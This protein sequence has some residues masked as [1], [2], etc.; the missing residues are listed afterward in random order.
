MG[1]E[2]IGHNSDKLALKCSGYD[3]VLHGQYEQALAPLERALEL[4]RAELRVEQ[5]NPREVDLHDEARILAH[6]LECY[7]K[8]ADGGGSPGPLSN[9]KLSEH[10]FTKLLEHLLN[11]VEAYQRF[12]QTTF[13]YHTLKPIETLTKTAEKLKHWQERLVAQAGVLQ[14]RQQKEGQEDDERLPR[15]ISLADLLKNSYEGVV[16]ARGDIIAQGKLPIGT[17]DALIRALTS[18]VNYYAKVQH[19]IKGDVEQM[20]ALGEDW[21]EEPLEFT[22]WL[23]L[24]LAA[25]PMQLEDESKLIAQT[26]K[27]AEERVNYAWESTFRLSYWL[28]KWRVRFPTDTG[29]LAA[30]EESQPFFPM[31]IRFY[32]DAAN[33]AEALV[34][35]ERARARAFA[36]LL[37]AHDTVQR[38]ATPIPM[39]GIERPATGS[40]PPTTLENILEVVHLRQSITIEYFLTQHKLI[41]WVITP[42]GG[43]ETIAVP[44]GKDKLEDIVRRFLQMVQSLELSPQERIELSDILQELYRYLVEPIPARLIPPSPEEVI[45]IIPHGPLFQVPFGALKNKEG[46]Y[47]IEEHALIYS[48]S[49][50]DLRYTSKNKSRVAHADN[51]TLLALVNPSLPPGSSF[52]TLKFTERNFGSIAAFYPDHQH[53]KIYKGKDA[54]KQTLKEEAS[55]CTVL[56]LVTHGKVLNSDPLH[57]YLVLANTTSS[58]DDN[59]SIP[60]I[61]H[62]ALHTDLVFLSSCE[63]DLGQLMGDGICRL[64]R[65]FTTAGTSSLLVGLW[66]IPETE[67]LQHLYLFHEHWRAKGLSKAQALRQAQ[68]EGLKNY[69]EQPDLWS[70]FALIGEGV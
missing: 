28:E 15:M 11:S 5:P 48:P 8:L 19:R 49:I 47:F 42:S 6:L 63:T 67:S 23:A 66:S 62:L 36:D 54:T 56:C 51:P 17:H 29:K 55:H 60:E 69:P 52:G 25:L 20:L 37:A 24:L 22:Q 14:Q 65:A 1:I 2:S 46:R 57:S 12:S 40:A 21:P 30:E 33:G 4:Y 45:T 26:Q 61:F 58:E 64:S 59:L 53:S 27:E 70:A 44:I 32:V 31:L 16:A 7:F 9:V 3:L 13:Q 38:R 18:L 68:L 43:I 39:A 10:F 50:N 41:I 34:L 35:S